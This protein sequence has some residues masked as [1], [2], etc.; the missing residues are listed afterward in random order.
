MLI[1]SN[2]IDMVPYF[3]ELWKRD[4]EKRIAEEER[5]KQIDRNYLLQT[6]LKDFANTP[7]V[8]N[9]ESRQRL[10]NFAKEC[11]KDNA[12][13]HQGYYLET[14]LHMKQFIKE[15]LLAYYNNSYQ[16]LVHTFELMDSRDIV[17]QHL[18]KNMSLQYFVKPDL[19]FIINRYNKRHKA[20]YRISDFTIEAR[21]HECK[22]TWLL[23]VV[24]NVGP[25]KAG[26][27][28]FFETLVPVKEKI[29]EVLKAVDEKKKYPW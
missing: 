9:P 8:K 12:P 7:D 21:L 13:M 2:D 29:N 24:Q 4:R 17:D 10:L 6:K 16:K 11:V 28:G 1:D 18:S 26:D 15:V 3:Q 23:S 20:L 22:R 14:E 19:F 27:R 25:D 5:D